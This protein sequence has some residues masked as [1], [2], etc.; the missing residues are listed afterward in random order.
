[1][2]NFDFQ[3]ASFCRSAIKRQR[4]LIE[5]KIRCALA[6]LTDGIHLSRQITCR[7]LAN[8]TITEML[9]MDDWSIYTRHATLWSDNEMFFIRQLP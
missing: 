8:N 6:Y 2:E 5:C 4:K 9:S 3:T 1:M 7:A